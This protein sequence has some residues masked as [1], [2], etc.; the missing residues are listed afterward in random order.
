M[1]KAQMQVMI[2]SYIEQVG[3]LKADVKHLE[4]QL[5]DSRSILNCPEDMP[6]PSWCEQVNG[7]QRQTAE[8]LSAATERADY[9]ATEASGFAETLRAISADTDHLDEDG[10]H[11]ELARLRAQHA[12]EG[13]EL[14]Q[15]LTAAQ[16]EN[17]RLKKDNSILRACAKTHD[18]PCGHSDQYTYSGDGGK[19]NVCLLC[20]IERL[21]ADGAAMREELERH[22]ILKGEPQNGHPHIDV[23]CDICGAV[24]FHDSFRH[25]P[26]C[27]LAKP[28]PGDGLRAENKRLREALEELLSLLDSEEEVTV[29]CHCS[30]CDDMII[31]CCWCRAKDALAQPAGE[32]G[33]E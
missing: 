10:V 4:A 15:Q 19:H 12:L 9:H 7:V 8:Q 29:G 31:K 1:N 26:D 6:L 11:G 27:I 2:D 28:H 33:G 25:K 14:E 24:G 32:K 3:H 5:A 23:M 13:A 18:A 22:V 17:E 30:E 16:A 21:T 20:E